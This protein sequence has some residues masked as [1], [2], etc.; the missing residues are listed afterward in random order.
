MRENFRLT[1]DEQRSIANDIRITNNVAGFTELPIRHKSKVW[2]DIIDKNDF[3]V[4][5]GTAKTLSPRLTAINKIGVVSW[6]L[7]SIGTEC[8]CCFG[9]RVTV[10]IVLSFLIGFLTRGYL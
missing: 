5:E 1:H 3:I 9:I 10:V 4:S 7:F 6:R 8:T 2:I